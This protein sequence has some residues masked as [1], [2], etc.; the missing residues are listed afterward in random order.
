LPMSQSAF[1]HQSPT[2]IPRGGGFTIMGAA[3]AC[4]GSGLTRARCLDTGWARPGRRRLGHQGA[5]GPPRSV[6]A[7][8]PDEHVGK[9]EASRMSSTGLTFQ[10]PWAS[11]PR[12]LHRLSGAGGVACCPASGSA[13]ILIIGWVNAGEDK[14]MEDTVRQPPPRSDFGWQL[15][16]KLGV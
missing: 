6:G 14:N 4:Q 8:S 15:E 16:C 11:N 13:L 2:K 10:F 3:F 5:G 9:G 7:P 12:G 1:R